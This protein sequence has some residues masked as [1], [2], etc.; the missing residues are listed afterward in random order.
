[1]NERLFKL[2][3]KNKDPNDIDFNEFMKELNK[4]TDRGAFLFGVTFIDELLKDLLTFF[5]DKNEK[6][7]IEKTFDYNGPLGTFSSRIKIAYCLCLITKDEYD[8]LDKLRDLRNDF[9]HKLLSNLSIGNDSIKDRISNL[10][11]SSR[12][13]KLF[14]NPTFSNREILHASFFMLASAIKLRKYKIIKN[15]PQVF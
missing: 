10:K 5:F 6:D 7:F 12:T 8:D 13:L 11:V 9:A 1:M 15:N 3:I 2:P 14:K 4:E